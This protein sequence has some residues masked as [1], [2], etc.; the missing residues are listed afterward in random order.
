M[1]VRK[2]QPTWLNYGVFLWVKQEKPN[3]QNHKE[4]EVMKKILVVIFV[5]LVSAVFVSTAFAQAKPEAKP[6]EKPAAASEKTPASEKAP[7]PEK[8]E[9]A[10][11]TPKPKP[12]PAGVVG[13]V[14]AI[15][16]RTMMIKSKKEAVGFDI[17]KTTLK[18]YK[19]IADVKVGDTVAAKY[20]KDG[21][22]ISKIKGAPAVKV[23]KKAE[24]P[25]K[26]A[27]KKEGPRPAPA[28]E[29]KPAEVPA[30]K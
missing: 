18:G 10:P 17:G 27:P 26:K 29:K 9:K 15:D 28:P 12:K 23:E 7:A 5:L 30:K 21:V 8:A 11:E 22:M 13:K 2:A 1:W 4:E 24:K 25:T 14:D 3:K 19:A 20:T 16:G 6:V